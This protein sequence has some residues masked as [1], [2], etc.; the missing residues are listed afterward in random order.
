MSAQEE[1][2]QLFP[3]LLAGCSAL[4][5]D[6]GRPIAIPLAIYDTDDDLA[7]L[8][9][10]DAAVWSAAFHREVMIEL[11]RMLAG[12]GFT[13]TLKP[14]DAGAY[15]GWLAVHTRTNTPAS[16]AAFIRM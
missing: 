12:A 9:P 6:F 5:A 2:F 15:L 4:C 8:R 11:E 3:V 7:V 14:V 13:V 1:A 16:R 10:E